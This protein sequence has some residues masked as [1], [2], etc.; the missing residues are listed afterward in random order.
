MAEGR[1]LE[2]QQ[3]R[4][5]LSEK[6]KKVTHG[7][8]CNEPGSCRG[9]TKLARTHG[10]KGVDDVGLD[11]AERLVLNHNKDL[12]LFLQ[13]DEVTEPGPLRQPAKC[14]ICDKLA[15]FTHFHQLLSEISGSTV[16]TSWLLTL[17]EVW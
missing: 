10:E 15:P 13:T 9:S 17:S 7:I 8:I 1:D 16:S 6:D 5:M 4:V 3:K 14:L 11:G 12:L 2:R